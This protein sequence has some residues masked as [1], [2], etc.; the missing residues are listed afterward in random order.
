MPLPIHQHYTSLTMTL[1]LMLGVVSGVLHPAQGWNILVI[2]TI[3][4]IIIITLMTRARL[5]WRAHCSPPLGPRA[6]ASPSATPSPA[7]PLTGHNH[8]HHYHYIVIIIII[9]LR[10]LLHPVNLDTDPDAPNFNNDVVL[11][12][13]IDDTLDHWKEAQ[14]LYTYPEEHTVRR[15]V[16]WRQLEKSSYVINCKSS[17]TIHN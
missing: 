3:T 2:I 8:H 15:C 13:L 14:V 12:T 16:M 7:S 10:V 1:D 9:R 5:W 11:A 6:T 17:F 4:I